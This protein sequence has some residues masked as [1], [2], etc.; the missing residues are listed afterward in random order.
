LAKYLSIMYNIN[1]S[2]VEKTIIV[3]RG[4]DVLYNEAQGSRLTG[5]RGLVH[6]IEVENSDWF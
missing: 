2:T 3:G 6:G 4:G 5:L 1:N